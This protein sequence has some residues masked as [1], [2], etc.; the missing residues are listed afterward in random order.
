MGIPRLSRS[1]FKISFKERVLRLGKIS[2]VSLLLAGALSFGG[3]AGYRYFGTEKLT[4]NEDDI[5]GPV[6]F[7][8]S[9]ASNYVTGE[10]LVMDGGW[11]IW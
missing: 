10:T 8:A 7:L 3:F 4:A 9:D 1:E 5:K 6:V 11:T 2:V